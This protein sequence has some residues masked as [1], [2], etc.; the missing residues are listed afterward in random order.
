MFECAIAL[1]LKDKYKYYRCYK[2][3]DSKEKE[4]FDSY[5]IKC[6]ENLLN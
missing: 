6:L 2:K 4:D 1:I 3:L 5:P